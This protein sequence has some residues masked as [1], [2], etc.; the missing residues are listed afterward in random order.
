MAYNNPLI[1]RLKIKQMIIRA[2]SSDKKL[3]DID[4]NKE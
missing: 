3:A 1:K 2:Y 4:N